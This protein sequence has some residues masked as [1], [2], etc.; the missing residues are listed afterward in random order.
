VRL[1]RTRGVVCLTLG[2]VSA[3]WW[4]WNVFVERIV[5]EDTPLWHG[6]LVSLV[7]DHHGWKLLVVE[8]DEARVPRGPLR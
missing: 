4:A 3:C 7:F 2:A 8:G 6:P 1:R 5:D